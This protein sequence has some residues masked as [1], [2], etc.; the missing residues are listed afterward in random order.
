MDKEII[1]ISQEEFDILVGAAKKS[2]CHRSKCGSII[3]SK[4]GKLIGIGYN[5]M[6]CDVEAAYFK[7]GLAAGFKS[8]KTCCVHAEQRAIM[9]AMKTNPSHIE[10]SLLLFIRLDENDEPKRSGE[11][12]C[13]ICSKMALDAGVGRFALWHKEGWTAYETN[14]YNKLSFEY[15]K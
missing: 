2:A 13:T 5:S 10:E 3:I 15:G 8:D 1:N 9:D 12:Y 6:P 14:Y 11:L 7:D 4:E